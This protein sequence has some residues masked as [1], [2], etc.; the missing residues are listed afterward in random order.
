MVNKFQK[1]LCTTI[2]DMFSYNTLHNEAHV[3][4]RDWYQTA[5]LQNRMTVEPFKNRQIM[6]NYYGL[7]I[8][9][10]QEDTL[11]SVQTER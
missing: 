1:C 4:K 5:T 11:K 9:R 10:N 8:R 2:C 3:Q 6:Q 7:P